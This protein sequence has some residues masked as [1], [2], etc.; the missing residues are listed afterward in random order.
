MGKDTVRK[1]QTKTQ[2]EKRNAIT[3]PPCIGTGGIRLSATGRAGGKAAV[4]GGDDGV[5][6]SAS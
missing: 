4:P 3:Q 5:C 2:D 6:L 1:C